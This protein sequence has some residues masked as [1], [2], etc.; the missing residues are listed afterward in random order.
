M[1]V[2]GFKFV[3]FSDDE[4]MHWILSEHNI[5]QNKKNVALLRALGHEL[6]ATSNVRYITHEKFKSFIEKNIRRFN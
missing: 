6:R 3:S 5:S 2:N 4:V 1:L